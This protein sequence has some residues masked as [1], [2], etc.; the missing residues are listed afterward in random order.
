MKK[1]VHIAAADVQPDGGDQTG[2]GI[3]PG[4]IDAPENPGLCA[5]A[6]WAAAGIRNQILPVA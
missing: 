3:A 1:S 6:A 2:I 5:Q 4:L